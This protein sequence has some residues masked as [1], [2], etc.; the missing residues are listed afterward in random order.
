MD[1]LFL[2]QV[3]VP[4]IIGVHPH[5]Q[6]SQQVLYIDLEIAANIIE[7][8]RKDELSLTVDY[9]AV[10][11]FLQSYIPTTRY[12]LLE[13]LAVHLAENLMSQFSLTGLRLTITKHPKDL[14][15]L[16]AAGICLTR[17][18]FF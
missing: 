8:G 12:R 10:Y 7:A 2:R 1:R 6:M 3:A 18:D 4:A 11:H 9:A 15:N 16:S 13:S 17:G 14:P 5:E